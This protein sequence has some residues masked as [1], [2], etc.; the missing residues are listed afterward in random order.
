MRRVAIAAALLLAAA[1]LVGVARPE[2]AHAVDSAPAAD[3]VTVGGSGSVVAVPTRASLSLGV[4]SRGDTAK[5]ALAANARAMRKVIDAVK[6]AGGRDVGTQSVSLSEVLG[7]NGELKGYAASNIVSATIDV[8]QAGAVI[9]AAV[10][11]G[12][13]QVYGPSLS[14][15][16]QSALYRQALKAAVSDA[17]ARAEVLATAAGRTLGKVTSI[18]EGGGPMPVESF[19]KAA[20]SDAAPTPVEAGTQETTASVSITFELT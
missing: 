9:D 11:A 5:A 10:A 4:S 1:A 12:A 6:A 16:D 14:V 20:A 17:H 3:F 7:D 15:D 18:S 8:K 13:N 2:G 19:Q